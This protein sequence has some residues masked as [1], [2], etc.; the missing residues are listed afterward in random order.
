MHACPRFL[1]VFACSISPSDRLI[2]TRAF[3]MPLLLPWTHPRCQSAQ[4]DVTGG[5][6][7]HFDE[8]QMLGVKGR[9]RYFPET[10]GSDAQPE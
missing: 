2:L 3:E 4:Q 9:G 7:T 10:G 8:T 6:G 1:L 5:M